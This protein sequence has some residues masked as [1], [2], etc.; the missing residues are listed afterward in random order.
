MNIKTTLAVLPVVALTPIICNVVVAKTYLSIEQAKEVLFPKSY[1]VRHPVELNPELIY[2]MRKISGVRHP[3]NPKEV[4]HVGDGSWFI[5][6]EVVGKHEMIKYAVGIDQNGRIRGV[7]IMQ[8]NESYGGEVKDKSWRQQFIGK[9]MKDP[10]Q[11]RV[12]IENIAGATLSSKHLTDGVKRLMVM[13]EAILKRRQ[14]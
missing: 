11:L 6:D 9:S 13:H 14:L 10:I 12:D 2:Q 5:V 4:W 3:F 8:Y 1:M 7:E